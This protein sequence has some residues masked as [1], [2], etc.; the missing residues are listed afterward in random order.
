MARWR[1]KL[2]KL[3]D[4]TY[5]QT[6]T[7]LNTDASGM[8]EMQIRAYAVRQNKYILIKAPP[9]S[10][11]SRALMFIALDKLYRQGLK[12]VIVAVPERAIARSFAEQQ[13]TENGFFADWK[14]DKDLCV[15]GGETAKVKKFIRFMEDKQA[16]ILLCTHATLRF[17]VRELELTM[18][19]NILLAVDEFH[20]VSA[21]A[22]N[23]LGDVMRQVMANSK[24]HVVAMTGSYFRGD[25]VPVLRPED[26]AQFTMVNYDYYEQLNGYRYLKNLSIGYHFYQGRYLDAINEVLDSDKKTIIHIPHV[27]SGESTKDKCGEVDQIIDS[28]G[29]IIDQDKESGI[30]FVKR[31]DDGKVLKIADLVDNSAIREKVVTYLRKMQN[32]DDIDIIIA[33]GMAKEGFDWPY[34]QHALT[35]GFR[36]SLTEIVQIIGR[37]TRDS[38]NKTQAQFTNLIAQPDATDSDVKVGV[39][40]M[41]KAISASLLME[42]VLAPNLKFKLKRSDNDGKHVIEI[43]GFKEAKSDRAKQIIATDLNDLKASI[44]QH[45]KV[46]PALPREDIDPEII[47]KVLIPRVI[48][49]KYPDLDK[50]QIE[51]VRQHIVADSVIKNGKIEQKGDKRFVQMADK[52]VNIDDLHIDLIDKV[53]PFQ[54]SFEILSKQMNPKLLKTIRD[55]IQATK[56]EVTEQEAVALYHQAGQFK[57]KHGKLPSITSRDS[58]EKRMAEAIIYLRNKRRQRG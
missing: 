10:G 14:L 25:A 39:N 33:L 7:S 54:K 40:N 21:D 23:R 11:K 57:A 1:K 47:N 28:I 37:V 19:D 46:L 9:A 43:K 6:G 8:R 16:K 53:N 32:I 27:G 36:A 35:I 48:Q 34:C 42:Q 17:A 50:N 4:V 31:H 58:K 29:E 52:F 26:E 15:S 30:T 20:H 5:E 56:I 12:K 2:P 41:L 38:E 44:L 13:L 3:I 45:D 55:I 49:E 24:A 18:F 22:D 51:E